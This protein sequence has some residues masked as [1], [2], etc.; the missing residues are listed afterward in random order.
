MSRFIF[1]TILTLVTVTKNSYAQELPK[2][3]IAEIAEITGYLESS[4]KDKDQKFSALT[5]DFDCQGL[6]LGYLNWTI[7]GGSFFG[8]IENI[9]SR[10]LRDI[11]RSTMP[12]YGAEWQQMLKL[13]LNNDRVRALKMVRDW[14]RPAYKSG[15]CDDH[16][17]SNVTFESSTIVKE[18]QSFLKSP[19]IR[20]AQLQ[21]LES[22]AV[23][24][25]GKAK[26]WARKQRGSS[27]SVRFN[28]FAFFFDLR[29]QNGLRYSNELMDLVSKTY[30]SELWRWNYNRAATSWIQIKWDEVNRKHVRDGKRNAIRWRGAFD[31]RRVD[32]SDN[33]LLLLAS[34]RGML[35]KRP[36]STDTMNR[37]GL[38]AMGFGWVHNK[39][40][41]NRKK[42]KEMDAL[43]VRN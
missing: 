6:S 15:D 16:K 21:G 36:Y 42:Y 22:V 31:Q 25:F 40:F 18:I 29:T 10:K 39:F 33:R 2:E 9:D 43:I 11:T 4:G 1:L 17:R 7:A 5:R 8:I 35:S 32:L 34:I 26:Q 20:K 12:N 24:A 27:H 19:E 30:G 13:G 3:W 41:D 23:E 37:K 28:E 38:M 14:Q